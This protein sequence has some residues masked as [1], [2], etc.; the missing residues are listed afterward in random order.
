MVQINS[1]HLIC[2]DGVELRANL[3]VQNEGSCKGS[4]LIL[5]G[6]GISQSLYRPFAHYLAE[7]GFQVLTI[8]YRGIGQSFRKELPP[9]KLSLNAWAKQDAVTAFRYLQ[10]LDENPVLI[11]GHS[12]GGQAVCLAEELDD[13]QG[14]VMVASQS[15][16]WRHWRGMGRVK[17]WFFWH[18]YLPFFSQLGTYTLS[19]PLFDGRLP[20]GVAREWARWGRDPE[21]LKGHH[22]EVS[23]RLLNR[24]RNIVAYAFSDDD[25]APP[26]AA[27]ALWQWFP[28]DCL[29]GHIMTPEELGVSRIGHFSA[30][31]SSFEST[32]WRSW[33][34]DFDN[35]LSNDSDL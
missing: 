4:I 23:E 15:G 25:F 11:F 24:D 14:V 19:T 10:K 18:C 12:F 21:Y 35:F 29:Q 33:C 3:F 30:F 26:A 9:H 13:A 7:G 6:V 34:R 5:P 8:D 17:L 20:A 32:L 2:E 27:R 22:A 28:E 16:Y 1:V 31:R